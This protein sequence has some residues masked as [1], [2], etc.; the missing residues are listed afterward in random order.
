MKRTVEMA[1]AG[2]PSKS[3]PSKFVSFR[4]IGTPKR[5]WREGEPLLYEKGT[6]ANPRRV[7]HEAP[8]M[9]D[10]PLPFLRDVRSI[11]FA[12]KIGVALSQKSQAIKQLFKHFVLGR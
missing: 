12:E 7:A 5:G 6:K 4:G 11:M 8:P 2:T 1:T 10:L 3:Q 9:T